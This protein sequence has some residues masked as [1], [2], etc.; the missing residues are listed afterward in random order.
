M[1]TAFQTSGAESCRNCPHR[2]TDRSRRACFNGRVKQILIRWL[3]GRLIDDLCLFADDACTE[4]NRHEEEIRELQIA[5]AEARKYIRALLE[6]LK[7][8]GH[9]D[10]EPDPAYVP[11]APVMRKVLRLKKLK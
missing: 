5:L 10:F 1:T 3:F 6:F 11:P 7:L 4:V 2:P 8:E 9:D